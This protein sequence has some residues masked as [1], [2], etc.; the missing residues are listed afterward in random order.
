[1]IPKHN[2]IAVFRK[3]RDDL[4]AQLDSLESGR[5]RRREKDG[6]KWV[7]TTDQAIKRTKAQLAE[8]DELLIGSQVTQTADAP[9]AADAPPAYYALES[10]SNPRMR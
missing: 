4:K 8:I 2:F 1:V 9:A 10:D 7:D 3:L 6:R 5:A